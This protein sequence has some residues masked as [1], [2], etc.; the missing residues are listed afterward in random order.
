MNRWPPCVAARRPRRSRPARPR[1]RPRPRRQRP[2]PR[3]TR[4]CEGRMARRRGVRLDAPPRAR[5]RAWTSSGAWLLPRGLARARLGS[6]AAVRGRRE[7]VIAHGAVVVVARVQSLGARWRRHR[8]G[9]VGQLLEGEGIRAGRVV[10][11]GLG[12]GVL[13]AARAPAVRGPLA[14]RGHQVERFV[15]GG[16]GGRGAGR[17]PAARGDPTFGLHVVDGGRPDGGRH[18]VGR[19][20]GRHGARGVVLAEPAGLVVGGGDGAGRHVEGPAGLALAATGGEGEDD[21]PVALGAAGGVPLG[22][23][24]V[25]ATAGESLAG[26]GGQGRGAGATGAAPAQAHGAGQARDVLTLGEDRAFVA[27]DLLDRPAGPVRDLLRREAATDQGLHLA[28]T[29]ATV[30]LDLQLTEPWPVTTGGGAQGFV[31]LDPE[32][33]PLGIGQQKVLAVLLHTDQPQVAHCHRLQYRHGLRTSS[34]EDRAP[35][36]RLCHSRGRGESDHAA[37]V[38]LTSRC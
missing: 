10:A 22:R 36:C 13:A 33:F 3:R 31:E 32:A 20:Q 15:R 4:R 24:R 14:H 23:G 9:V 2:R 6:G 27:T 30:D 29:H 21:G 37:P 5:R 12:R 1:P 34:L 11:R 35:C 18:E 38:V 26:P 8:L 16:T 7:D 19:G 28:G 17:G 25:D